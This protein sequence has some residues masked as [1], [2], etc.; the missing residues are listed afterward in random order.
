MV[1]RSI[2]PTTEE[3]LAEFEE[4][5]SDYIDTVLKEAQRAFCQWRR[6]SFEEPYIQG[7][8]IKGPNP[9]EQIMSDEPPTFH[10]IYDPTGDYACL[11]LPP[12]PEG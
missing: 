8:T 2:N 10:L 11:P 7:G 5:T 1:I 9:D 4:F 6:T 12:F 3:V